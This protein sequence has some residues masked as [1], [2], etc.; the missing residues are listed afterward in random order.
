MRA[1]FSG[2]TATWTDFNESD[3]A[4][5][6]DGCWFVQVQSKSSGGAATL[7]ST[8]DGWD[9]GIEGPRP[10]VWS[11]ASSAWG[12]VVDQRLAAVGAPSIVGEARPFML[13]PLVIAMPQPMAEA[14]GWPD[15]PIGFADILELSTSAEGWSA[16][17]HPEWGPFKL[18]KTNPNFST[19]G[20]SM[21][22]AQYS[23]LAGK[24]GDLTVEDLR[25]ADVVASTESIEQAVVHY[26]DTT[27]TFLNNWYR[28]DARGTALSYASAVAVEEVSVIQYNQGNPDGRLD[29]G[30]V[31]VE[32]RVPLVAVYPAEGT[33]FS[34]N[35]FIVLDAEW[36]TPEAR[37]GA[38][39]F[40][41]YVQQPE[42]QQRV[43]EFGFRPGNP[44]VPVADPIVAAN[45]VDPDQPQAL[46]ELPEPEVLVSVIDE[47]ELHRKGARVL[48]VIDISGSMGDPAA[49]GLRETKL[50]L[51]KS[52]AIRSLEQFAP[53]DEV[54]L[55]VFTTGI[56][57]PADSDFASHPDAWVELVEPVAISTNR[58]Q[59]EA[60]IDGL[61]PQQGTPLYTATGD[62]YVD[63][64]D[65]LDPERINAVVVLSDGQ[66]EDV[67]DDLDGLLD[68]LSQGREGN[69][70]PVRV[71]TIAYG[72]GADLA[73]LQQIA[74]A[75][76]AAV[77][78]SAD[79][80]SIDRVFT[81]VISN[82]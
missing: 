58:A 23:A 79:P 40:G 9:E 22:V 54:G 29:P 73:T 34:D 51:A 6:D 2:E 52:A 69:P 74:E 13:T 81:A 75:T 10:T 77:Y 66:N 32:P 35:P 46:L 20:L 72:E 45:G 57:V 61:F 44:A 36:V 43:L 3:L 80:T 50:D 71:F 63:A 25:R 18:G 31:P 70:F 11:P 49:D 14:L 26:G 64:A 39:R 55:R 24:T 53:D 15:T 27:L 60:A 38:E 4:E 17:G 21:A 65:E 7:L 28:A 76:D 67:N 56:S 8:P 68:T 48:L 42:N 16:F 33:L 30:E 47:W 12:G 19:S 41:G 62:A 78:D 1:I 37:A 5:G 82:F 59:L